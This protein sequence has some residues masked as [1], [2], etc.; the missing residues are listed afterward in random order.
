MPPKHSLPKPKK[1]GAPASAKRLSRQGSGAPPARKLTATSSGRTPTTVLAPSERAWWDRRLR[2]H[3][4]DL[5]A[6]DA[7]LHAAI[8][9]HFPELEALLEEVTR[10]YEDGA[11]RFWHQSFKVYALQGF[12]ARV[13]DTLRSLSPDRIIHP[14]FELI[15]AAGTGR[16]FERSHNK[17][18]LEETRPIV[19]AFLHA[20]YFLEMI[21]QYGRELKEAP[22]ILPSG[23]AAVLQLYGIR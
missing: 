19:E 4:D 23:W 9:A 17:R 13:A 18:W 14:W 7:E 6:A 8:R 11:Y 2:I 3:P 1:R 5:T 22:K 16:K 10:H 12:I 20:K 15:V 21:C